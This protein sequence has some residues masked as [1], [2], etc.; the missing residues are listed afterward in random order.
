MKL[1]AVLRDAPEAVSFE[2]QPANIFY[3]TDTPPFKLP[4]VDGNRVLELTN[5]IREL[6]ESLANLKREA[7]KL[8]F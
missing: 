1:G 7:G 5:K 6:M 8:G 3:A 4:D 2:N